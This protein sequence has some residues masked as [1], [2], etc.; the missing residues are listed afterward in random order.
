LPLL[1]RDNQKQEIELLDFVH[2]LRWA[3]LL[4]CLLM[5]V[6][7]FA[8]M[9]FMIWR[10]HRT[11]SGNQSNFHASVV[12]EI[13]WTLV[14]FVIVVMLVWPTAKIFLTT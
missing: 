13:C 11:G 14:P 10:H 2:G 12:V 3:L 9:F 5:F 6:F 1:R 4:L 7:G 8:L